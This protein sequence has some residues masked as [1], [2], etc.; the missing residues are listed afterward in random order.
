MFLNPGTL[1]PDGIKL[2]QGFIDRHQLSTRAIV[3]LCLL[4]EDIN[5]RYIT[6]DDVLSTWRCYGLHDWAY[7]DFA[8]VRWGICQCV[9]V[10]QRLMKLHRERDT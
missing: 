7:D 1:S 6:I 3:E 4:F 10:Y 8:D 2:V 5:S 9:L